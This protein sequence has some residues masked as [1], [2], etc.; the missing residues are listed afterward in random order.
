MAIELPLFPLNVVLFP[1]ADLPL[2]IFEARY[3]LM[4]K[5]C[6]EQEK[7]F[8]VVLARPGSQPMREEPYDVGTMAE[9]LALSRMDDGR[10]N[11]IARGGQR[12]RILEQHRAKP[13]LI[14]IVEVYRD[15]P[16]PQ[17]ALREEA[18]KAQELFNTYLEILLEVVGKPETQFNLPDDPEE[19]SHFIAYFLDIEDE[20]KQHLL[21]MTMTTQRL[22]SVIEMLR[23]EVPF[24]RQM[25]SM[26][27]IYR[28]GGPDHSKLN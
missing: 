24:V 23:R 28:A 8:G 21:E 19:L 5:E 16:E 3:R 1:G 7:P 17:Q 10:M 6:Y 25:L 26:S 2:H 12:F 15:L 20:E 27:N 4:I 13:Y 18:D 14:G 11:L 22:G 9:I